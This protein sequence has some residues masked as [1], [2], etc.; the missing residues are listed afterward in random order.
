[1]LLLQG[2]ELLSRGTKPVTVEPHLSGLI[3]AAS[4]SVIQKIRI[5]GFFFENRLNW[6]S[7][8][9]LL[10]FT[11]IPASKGFDHA[12]FELLEAVTL[13]RT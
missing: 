4:H 1:M 3:G 12:L 13:Y 2:T 8:F 10:Q 7:E 9:R 6:Q 11:E 5:I